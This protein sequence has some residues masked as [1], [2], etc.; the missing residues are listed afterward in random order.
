M[1]SAQIAQDIGEVKDAAAAMSN[2]ST[3][4]DQSAT[5][6]SRLAEEL[7]TMVHRFKV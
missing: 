1:V 6:L 4:V 2:N 5:A 3:Q 7:N